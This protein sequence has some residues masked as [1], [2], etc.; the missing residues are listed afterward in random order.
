MKSFVNGEPAYATVE[1]ADG[2]ISI[3]GKVLREYL[4]NADTEAWHYW[5]AC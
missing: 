4:R 3:Q 1:Y 2:K 5:F